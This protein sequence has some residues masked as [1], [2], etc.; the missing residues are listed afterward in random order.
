M[1]TEARRHPYRA[2]VEV[3]KGCARY[4]LHAVT[5][6]RT[7]PAHEWQWMAG[8]AHCVHRP[9]AETGC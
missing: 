4:C 9:G 1:E 5:K 2:S 3:E 7:S 6:P 8:K